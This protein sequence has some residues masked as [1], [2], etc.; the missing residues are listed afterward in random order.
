MGKPKK[1]TSPKLLIERDLSWLEFNDRVLREGMCPAVPPLERMKFLSIVSSNLDEFFM[2]RVAGWKQAQE[3]GRGGRRRGEMSPA[4]LLTQ[5]ASRVERMVAEQSA[6][7][8]ELISE[9]D[10]CGVHLLEPLRYTEA[11]KRFIR[12][13][14]ARDVEAA[15]TPLAIDAMDPKPLLPGLR[16]HLGLALREKAAG[17]DLRFAVI[18][19]PPSLPRLIAIPA[20]EG[21]HMARIEDVIATQAGKLFPGHEIVSVAAFRVTRDSD[22]SV[23]E[24]DSDDLLET[25]AQ[26]VRERTHRRVVRLEIHAGAHRALRKFLMTLFDVGPTDVYEIDGMLDLRD[27]MSLANRPGL[28]ALR[29]EDWPPQPP[30]DLYGVED[31]FAALR[32]RDVLLFHPYESFEPVVELARTAATDPQVLA[33]KQTLYRTTGDSPIVAALQQAARN[34]K[35]V[36]VLVELRARFDEAR[37]ITWARAL[38]AAGCDVIYGVAGLKTHAKM[39]LIVRREEYGLRRYLHLSTGNYNDKTARLYSDIGLMTTDRDLTADAAAFFNLLTG[40]SQQVGWSRL[41]IAPTGLRQRFLDLIEREIQSSTRTR[42]GW[43]LAKVNSLEDP[44][45]CRALYRA[46][47][48][49]VQIRLNVRGICRLRPGIKGVSENIEVVSLVDRYLEHSRIFYFRNGGHEEVYLSSADWMTRNLDKR[50]EV[51]FP[52]TDPSQQKRLMDI[53]QTFFRDN[54]KARRLLPD[55]TWQSVPPG[56]EP[57]R[58]QEIFYRQAVE[59]HQADRHNR[60]MFQPLKK[61]RKHKTTR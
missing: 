37:N 26:A 32:E 18:P 56:E 43:I 48:A 15:L 30:K 41:T 9:L 58:A 1:L 22:I 4:V 34:G 55:G 12:D 27:L 16:L 53:L 24:D 14:F 25:L 13:Y 45:I 57:I 44:D 21:L 39:L 47:Q 10:R 52:V 11:Q 54:V 6:A 2:I 51:L 38:E 17:N 46:S 29:Y 40:Y 28:E 3:S 42:P 5:I 50:L 8:K 19:I 20:G 60:L 7:L 35:Q 23:D 59:E 36:T 61:A 49:G 31:L 33:I